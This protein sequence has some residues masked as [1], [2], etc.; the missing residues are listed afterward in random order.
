MEII[1]LI[2][3]INLKACKFGLADKITKTTYITNDIRDKIREKV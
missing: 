1:T 2:Y 3:K